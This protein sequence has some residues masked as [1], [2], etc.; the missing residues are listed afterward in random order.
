VYGLEPI[1]DESQRLVPVDRGKLKASGFLEINRRKN[2][3]TVYMGYGRHGRPHY[4]AIVHERLDFQ[5]L[6]PTQAKY[7][8]DAVKTKLSTM[9]R[10]IKLFMS[11]CLR[12]E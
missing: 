11:K 10:R 8:E 9:E 5:H 1:Y 2:G 12:A 6:P 4:A 7:L 3:V